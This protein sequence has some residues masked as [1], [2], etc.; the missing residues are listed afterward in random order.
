VQAR[1]EAVLKPTAIAP[2][3]V[4]RADQQRLS[5]V[6][7][8]VPILLGISLDELQDFP[9]FIVTGFLIFWGSSIKAQYHGQFS[10]LAF[11]RLSSSAACRQARRSQSQGRILRL[12]SDTTSLPLGLLRGNANAAH[13][14]SIQL[15]RTVS[16]TYGLSLV[17]LE[18]ADD[19][20]SHLIDAMH[21]L[22]LAREAEKNAP[23]LDDPEAMARCCI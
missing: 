17:D 10:A 14:N 3:N 4:D 7:E 20:N 12:A 23:S 15:R 21:W 16:T 8:A 22:A 9:S 13:A 1:A 11:L 19:M 18:Q 5:V 6:R 2:V